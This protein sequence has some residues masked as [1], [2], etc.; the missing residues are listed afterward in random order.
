M[1]R[2]IIRAAGLTALLLAVAASAGPPALAIETRSGDTITVPAGTTID[3]DLVAAGQTVTIAGRVTGDVFAFGTTITVTGTVDRDLVAAGQR[4]TIDGVVRGDLRAAAQDV[5]INGR[6]EGNVTS[7]S[8]LLTVPSRGKIDGSVLSGAQNLY[9][10]GD[11]GRGVTAGAG[12]LQI[13]GAVGGNVQASVEHLVVDPSARVAGRLDYRSE[14]QVS[15]PSGTVAGGVQFQQAERRDRERERN[16]G[17]DFFAGLFGF[18]NLVWLVGSVIAG[19]LLV[20]F[21]PGFAAGTVAQVRERPLP[22]LGLGVL[23]LFVVPF[24]ILLVAFTLIGLPIAF[25]AGLGYLLALYAGWLLLGLAVGVLLVELVRRRNPTLRADPRWLVVLGL[26]VLYVLTHLP[27]IGGL[28]SF[29][30]VCLGLGALLLQ[31]AAAR[32]PPA[33]PL[34]AVPPLPPA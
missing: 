3:D 21:L 11:V 6:V 1:R 28:A 4:I 8:Q 29:T 16:E 30:A 33:A 7:G 17:R 19:V 32:R 2:V 5:V 27:W 22:S 34:P 9:L 20:H 31:I 14:D 10:Q 23:A 18:F 13:G 12:T 26:I 24:A 25:V 15:V